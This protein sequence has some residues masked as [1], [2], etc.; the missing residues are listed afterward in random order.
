MRLPIVILI[1]ASFAFAQKSNRIETGTV[2]AHAA[3]WIPP[4]DTFASPPASPPT[5]AVYIFTDAT[6]L[7]TCSGGGTARATCRWN[8]SAW[9]ATGGGGSGGG[10]GAGGLDIL[11]FGICII[12]GCGSE[13]TINYI[14]TMAGGSFTEC[15]FNLAVAPSGSSGVVVDVQDATGTSI[16][17]A[18]KLVLPQASTSVVYQSTFASSPQNYARSSKYK[19]VVLT[20]DS[21]NTA[22]G[23]TVQCR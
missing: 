5:G 20:N 2:D 21:G 15:A 16:F 14:A 18:T 1:L 8:G 19:A 7:G 9:E 6:S 3:N 4:T 11:R 17:G 22:Q 23:G 13:T 10:G 12:P